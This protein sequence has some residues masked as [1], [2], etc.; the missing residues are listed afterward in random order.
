MVRGWT[1][2]SYLPS[3]VIIPLALCS[4][5]SLSAPGRPSP[6][7]SRS[8]LRSSCRSST[9]FAFRLALL[10]PGYL[11]KSLYRLASRGALG[12]AK[13]PSAEPRGR[14]GRLSRSFW[15]LALVPLDH[16]D[17]PIERH[18][19][20]LIDIPPTVNISPS[21][22]SHRDSHRP[23]ATT[24][25]FLRPTKNEVCEP[26]AKPVPYNPVVS[27]GSHIWF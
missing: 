7:L 18:L 8:C 2:T 3:V 4:P 20:R 25:P 27:H 22:L 21:N 15:G 1:R 26:V 14:G 10:L 6:Q 23:P 16:W 11:F 12:H 19:Q 9:P 24:L 17:F 5:L 13:L